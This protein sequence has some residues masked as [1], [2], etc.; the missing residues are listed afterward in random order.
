MTYFKSLFSGF[1]L[2]LNVLVGGQ[3]QI[4]FNIPTTFKKADFS[5]LFLKSVNINRPAHKYNER[6]S[7]NRIKIGLVNRVQTYVYLQ[8]KQKQV[9]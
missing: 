7:I 3:I 1:K 2:V 9:E 4:I 8:G 6:F 5:F